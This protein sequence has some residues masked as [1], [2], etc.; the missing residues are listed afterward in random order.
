MIDMLKLT[1]LIH[2]NS[3]HP[4]DYPGETADKYVN[5][6]FPLRA[7]SWNDLYRSSGWDT[8]NRT[9]EETPEIILAPRTRIETLPKQGTWE[10]EQGIE[11]DMIEAIKIHIERKEREKR[12][13]DEGV[14]VINKV[15]SF[16]EIVEQYKQRR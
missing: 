7:I 5:Q 2:D 1:T 12:Y 16:M 10:V 3:F 14:Q 13:N 15:P 6:R 4:I 8:P 11:Q 9:S